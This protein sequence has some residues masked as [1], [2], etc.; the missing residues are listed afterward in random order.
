MEPLAIIT[1]IIVML[2]ISIII[3]VRVREEECKVKMGNIRMNS[4]M[5]I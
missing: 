2:I 1:E 5:I 4:M 3:M